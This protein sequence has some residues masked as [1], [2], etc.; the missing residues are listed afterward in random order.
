MLDQRR[1]VRGG[2]LVPRGLVYVVALDA[3]VCRGLLRRLG[4]HVG[5]GQAVSPW[6][7]VRDARRVNGR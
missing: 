2:L 1:P 5:D 3:R 6:Q 7:A 4:Q